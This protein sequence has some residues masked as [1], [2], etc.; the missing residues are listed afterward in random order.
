MLDNAVPIIC[1]ILA[2]TIVTAIYF[3]R[4][5][6]RDLMLAYVALNLGVLSVAAMLTNASVGLGL[7]LGLFGILSIIRLRS[8]SITQEE[9]A[10]YFVSLALGLLAGI[11]AG[12]IYLP[13][14]LMALLVLVMYVADHPRL[15][16]RARRELVTLDSA[17]PD[18][19]VLREHIENRLGIEVRHLM[20]QE[21]DFVRDV[22]VVDV[23]YRVLAQP[24]LLTSPDRP[25]AAPDVPAPVVPQPVTVDLLAPAIHP[26]SNGQHPTAPETR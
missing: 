3:Q 11:A 25:P 4:H 7:G 12:P 18:E 6:R 9:I 21:L 24:P 15:L 17:I 2:I 8:D 16:P 13:P 23:R 20:V 1:D 14:L 19:T 22:T 26:S 5:Q 10:Y